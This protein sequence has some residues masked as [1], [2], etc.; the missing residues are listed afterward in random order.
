MININIA[1]NRD[2]RILNYHLFDLGTEFRWNIMIEEQEKIRIDKYTE[3][4]PW[5][6]FEQFTH[7]E[8]TTVKLINVNAQSELSL[9]YHEYRSEFWKAISGNP[10]IVV[11]DRVEEAK[12]G[13][14]FFI[15]KLTEHQ[16]KTTDSPAQ[17]LEIAFGQFYEDDII[18]IKDRYNR[19]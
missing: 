7:N 15:P 16:I 18:R 6:N 3:V 14:E 9:Q 5:G 1:T 12:K 8:Q 11:G 17:I 2:H 19:V 4:R 13:D 10:I